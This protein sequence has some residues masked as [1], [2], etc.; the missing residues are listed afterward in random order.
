MRV[1]VTEN[2]LVER[3]DGKGMFRKGFLFE[4]NF[5]IIAGSLN[6]VECSLQAMIF[7]KLRI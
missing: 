5:S 4:N 3:P 6:A 1:L 7:K 2:G